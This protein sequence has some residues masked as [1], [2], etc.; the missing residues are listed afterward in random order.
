M[1][2]KITKSIKVISKCKVCK[3][4]SVDRLLIIEINNLSIKI[5]SN[6]VLSNPNLIKECPKC[7][8]TEFM[9]EYSFYHV[10]KIAQ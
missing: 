3:R 2:K 7:K 10:E 6:Q 8:G 5:L 9:R 4:K 1:S